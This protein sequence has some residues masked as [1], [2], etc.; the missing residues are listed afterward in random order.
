M[1]TDTKRIVI[2]LYKSSLHSSCAIFQPA[3]KSLT[4]FLFYLSNHRLRSY[5][6]VI[7]V[8]ADSERND[9]LLD[10]VEPID[11]PP[12]PRRR[13]FSIQMSSPPVHRY[14]D[15]HRSKRR[16]LSSYSPDTREI[17]EQM[18][19]RDSQVEHN[20]DFAEDNEIDAVSSG[21]GAFPDVEHP[22][23]EEYSEQ[24]DGLSNRE[25]SSDDEETDWKPPSP[26]DTQKPYGELMPLRRRRPSEV[27]EADDVEME[28]P[29]AIEWTEREETIFLILL[30]DF[31]RNWARIADVM[32]GRT[33]E[34][35]GTLLLSFEI[36]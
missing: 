14:K 35:V 21:S 7:A 19:D 36:H 26:W 31:G 28:K 15:M 24:P 6:L 27:S 17:L 33:A 34:D 11:Q 30:V 23:D 18:F 22:N 10:Q 12:R 1:T 16:R 3:T 29:A 32:T 4:L 5:R 25:S 13:S 8:M 20:H 2:S 9:N